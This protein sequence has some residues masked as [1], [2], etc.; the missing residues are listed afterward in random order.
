[1]VAAASLVLWPEM[2]EGLGHEDAYPAMMKYL[3]AG[4][5]GV[6]VASFWASY[7]STVSTQLNLAASFIVNDIYLRFSKAEW[8][9]E[10]GLVWL[11]RVTMVLICILGGTVAVL[12]DIYGVN[13]RTLW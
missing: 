6:M 4:L 10:R 3:P 8:H 9:S 1:M 13:I 7:M 12:Q 2:P 11:S 5:L